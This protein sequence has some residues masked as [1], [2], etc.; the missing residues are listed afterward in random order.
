MIKHVFTCFYF[1]LDVLKMERVMVTG[2][3][4]L[5]GRQIVRELHSASWDV[6]G[7]AYQRVGERMKRVDLCEETELRKAI[8]DF[9]VLFQSSVIT[10]LT[11]IGK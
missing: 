11:E 5:L 4:G 6:L 9:K 8:Q 10:Q 7:I 2:A 3:S 1:I